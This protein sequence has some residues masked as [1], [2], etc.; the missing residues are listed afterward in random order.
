MVLFFLVVWDDFAFNGILQKM[1]HY[2]VEPGSRLFFWNH[3][4][5]GY[6]FWIEAAKCGG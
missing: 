2:I 1:G 5:L 4:N 3:L 6:G